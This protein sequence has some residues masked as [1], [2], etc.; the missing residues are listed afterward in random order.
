MCYLGKRHSD[1]KFNKSLYWCN[2][3][4][5]KVKAIGSSSL[6][7]VVVKQSCQFYAVT[8]LAK[9]RLWP[10]IL[11]AMKLYETVAE[12]SFRHL[13]HSFGFTKVKVN[14]Y[15]TIGLAPK[16]NGKNTRL[17][18]HLPYPRLGK[19]KQQKS[20]NGNTPKEV[21]TVMY[22][23]FDK[24]IQLC[25]A[26]GAKKCKLGCSDIRSAFRNLCMKKSAWKFWLMKARSP[27]DGQWYYFVD[28]CLPFDASICCAH[29]QLASDAMAHIVKYRTKRDLV[30][31]LDDFLF[32]ALLANMCNM[33]VETFLQMCHEINL[34]I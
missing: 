11:L 10:Y 27:I 19:T 5:I 14:P 6:S 21:C 1:L 28:K 17:I 25:M 26:A 18:F 22:S 3:L 20:V 33:Q 2:A 34:P 31:Y 7:W 9:V 8:T 12:C 23:D 15:L 32:V 30:N 24:A 16:D 4:S 29:F 13:S